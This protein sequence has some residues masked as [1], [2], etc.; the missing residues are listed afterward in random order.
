MQVRQGLCAESRKSP[1]S[2]A[3]LYD[4]LC[5]IVLSYICSVVLSYAG[6]MLVCCVMYRMLVTC[7]CVLCDVLWGMMLCTRLYVAC[8]YM[9]CCMLLFVV[10]LYVV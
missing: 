7:W 8:C 5:T 2:D 9:S 6:H 1:F 4:V 10:L 3:V